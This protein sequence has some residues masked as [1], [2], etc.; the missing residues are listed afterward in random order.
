MVSQWKG[1]QVLFT[2]LPNDSLRQGF[3]KIVKENASDTGKDA[4]KGDLHVLIC[5][6]DENEE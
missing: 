4:L 2:D 5:R 6:A 1:R 3:V